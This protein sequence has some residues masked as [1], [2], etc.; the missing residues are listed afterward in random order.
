M[1]L[2]PAINSA[3]LTLK[4]VSASVPAQFPCQHYAVILNTELS[5]FPLLAPVSLQISL[6]MLPFN[7]TNQNIKHYNI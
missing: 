4:D 6:L 1:L 2:I 5:D 7:N 3:I